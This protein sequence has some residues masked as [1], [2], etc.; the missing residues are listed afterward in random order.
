MQLRLPGRTSCPCPTFRTAS[1]QR[2][3]QR[4]LAAR[5]KRVVCGMKTRHAAA[6]TLE[7]T[8]TKPTGSASDR[9][10]Q[11]G[12]E[13][14]SQRINERLAERAPVAYSGQEP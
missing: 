4:G 13:L 11:T 14:E 12:S 1:K 2:T 5:R 10:R 9:A 7:Y 8:P 6:L 3:T